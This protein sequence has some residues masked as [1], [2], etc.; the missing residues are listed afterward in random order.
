MPFLSDRFHEQNGSA[1]APPTTTNRTGT[2]DAAAAVRAVEDRVRGQP[3]AIEALHRAL[4]V[5]QA[6]FGDRERPLAS[7]LLVG[8][9]GVGK[10]EVVRRLAATLRSG[11]DDL[12]RVDMGQLAQ[13]HYAAAISG[14]PPGYAGSREEST[15][16]DRSRIE[17]TPLTPG[18]VLFDE[19]EKAH[20]V[21]LRALLAALDRGVLQPANGGRPFSFRNTLVF[22]TSNLGSGTVAR[23]RSAA[24]RRA[25]DRTAS[26]PGV[27]AAAGNAVRALARRDSGA[28]DRAVRDFFDPEFLN[29]LDEVVHFAE[30]T[31][32]VAREIVE[33]RLGDVAERL[34]RRDVSLEVDPDVVDHLARTGLDPAHGARS[35]SRLVH[36]E[37]VA[38]AA[39]A[40][41]H[42]RGTSDAP[43][44]LRV[45]LDRNGHPAVTVAAARP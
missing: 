20:S 27:R 26:V 29:R 7:L 2:F 33:L 5:A 23:Q 40:L 45:R 1:P 41:V 28:V 37:V 8:P 10:T 35:L 4:V 22:L 42:A 3:D 25:L 14:S 32:D 15:V 11:P 30:I 6:G 13:E 16:L 38:P 9:T 18:I 43:P 19:V 24:W 44:A 12:C 31:A 17:G 36:R 39:V 34:A 21:V